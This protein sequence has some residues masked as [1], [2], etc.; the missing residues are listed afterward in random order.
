MSAAAELKVHYVGLNGIHL[1]KWNTVF[2][3]VY[4]SLELHV[5]MTRY[6]FISLE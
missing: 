6:A 3:S 5:T 2:I 4:I 1:Q